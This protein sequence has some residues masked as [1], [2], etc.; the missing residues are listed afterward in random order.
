MNINPH[1]F[2]TNPRKFGDAKL[3]YFTVFPELQSVIFLL[4][5]GVP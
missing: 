4:S 1:A 5:F 3:H 2:G